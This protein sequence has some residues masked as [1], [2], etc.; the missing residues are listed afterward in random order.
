LLALSHAITVAIWQ[1]L[2]IL[3]QLAGFSSAMFGTIHSLSSC[4]S[5]SP[6]NP[7]IHPCDGEFR[8]GKA[9]M[10]IECTTK[11]A[12]GSLVRNAVGY[13]SRYSSWSHRIADGSASSSPKMSCHSFMRAMLSLLFFCQLMVLAMSRTLSQMLFWRGTIDKMVSTS[14][15]SSRVAV[16]LATC[17]SLVMTASSGL[18]DEAC[19]PRV[20]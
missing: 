8:S 15:C 7:H 10:P 20:W 17:G 12:F 11:T 19:L 2:I 4:V 14:A 13:A 16:W 18:V 5:T 9:T 6:M 3:K 1:S